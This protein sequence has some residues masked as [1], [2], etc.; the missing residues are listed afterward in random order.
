M[1]FSAPGVPASPAQT[2][3]YD[4]AKA[5]LTWGLA[6]PFSHDVLYDGAL[7]AN[8]VASMLLLSIKYTV[9]LP[10]F[11]LEFSYTVNTHFWNK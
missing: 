2:T 9:F 11:A 5:T 6:S 7:G 1:L 10:Y 8:V 3:V 4:V